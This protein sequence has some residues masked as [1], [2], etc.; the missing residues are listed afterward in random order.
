MYIYIYIHN[1][2]IYIYVCVCMYIYTC[3]YI[4][5]HKYILHTRVYTYQCTYTWQVTC[6]YTDVSA[7]QGRRTAFPVNLSA[8]PA[9]GRRGGAA[10]P[11]VWPLPKRVAPYN[12]PDQHGGGERTRDDE[13]CTPGT[14]EQKKEGRGGPVV[15][16]PSPLRADLLARF[17]PGTPQP[18]LRF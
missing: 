1:I 11:L 9:E 14:L 13:S 12:E 8:G 17:E 3:M 7:N 5:I 4:C 6:T 16:R 10:S 2:Y 15:M 18:P